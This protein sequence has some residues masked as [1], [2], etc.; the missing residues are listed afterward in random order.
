MGGNMHDFKDE[1]TS[2]VVSVWCDSPKSTIHAFG[3]ELIY[4]NAC[5]LPR[6]PEELSPSFFFTFSGIQSKF[7]LLQRLIHAISSFLQVCTLSM[8]S[9]VTITTFGIFL[10]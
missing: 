10:L 9:M 7:V 2:S 4:I 6:F 3:E 8:V 1:R 5:A